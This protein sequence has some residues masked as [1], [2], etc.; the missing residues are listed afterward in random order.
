MWKKEL[1][2]VMTWKGRISL[3][4][5]RKVHRIGVKKWKRR[6]H[7]NL[8]WVLFL[9]FIIW[10]GAVW[11]REI[12]R[13]YSIKTILVEEGTVEKKCTGTGFLFTEELCLSAP[14]DGIFQPLA[15]EGERVPAGM[16]VAQLVAVPDLEQRAAAL[17]EATEQ[18]AQLQQEG[19]VKEATLEESLIAK[20]EQLC[21]K[22]QE[23]KGTLREGEVLESR[24]LTGEMR[25]ILQER[26]DILAQLA[27][28][29]S[30]SRESREALLQRQQDLEVLLAEM[31]YPLKTPV[32]GVV[33]Y[34]L[35]EDEGRFSPPKITEFGVSELATLKEWE[36]PVYTT[37]A[38]AEVK[39]GTPLMRI[40]DNFT[41]HLV[42][43]MSREEA[44][45]LAGKKRVTVSFP[46]IGQG[47]VN[48]QVLESSCEDD[49]GFLKLKVLDYRP[50]LLAQRKLVVEITQA[51]YEG[52][53]IP[54]T[55]LLAGKGQGVGVYLNREGGIAFQPVE[56]VGGNEEMV[57]VRG[58]SLYDEVI[59]NP[60]RVREG[61][62]MR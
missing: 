17:E 12:I 43:L 29:R 22:V 3:E 55:A 25:A 27:R 50:E 45:A 6:P 4:I 52:L 30:L 1:D 7:R 32:A 36:I 38:G 62:R 16:V 20:T 47:E 39:A 54:R 44:Q 19:E 56:E 40:V 5:G 18:L 15:A 28:Q 8:L 26:Q 51:R 13:G 37:E 23:L 60:A 9:F 59:T 49:L 21:E 48:C 34:C 42:T 33:S 14:A 31:V 57:V 24:T 58:I 41:L 61:Q 10:T 11:C 35:P 2:N 46:E 53:V